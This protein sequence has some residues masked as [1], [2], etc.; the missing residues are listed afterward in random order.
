MRRPVG[1]SRHGGRRRR[2]TR[3]CSIPAATSAI[4][5]LAWTCTCT[6]RSSAPEMS[7]VTGGRS[8]N[9]P[10][11]TDMCRVELAAVGTDG[12]SAPAKLLELHLYDFSE[13]L[14]LELSADGTF[15]IAGRTAASRPRTARPARSPW[16]A[17]WRGCPGPAATS[18]R[19]SCPAGAHD[20]W[21]FGARLVP[22]QVLLLRPGLSISGRRGYR[23]LQMWSPVTDNEPE[24]ERPIHSVVRLSIPLTLRTSWHS[25]AC[26]PVA[27]VPGFV[28]VTLMVTVSFSDILMGVTQW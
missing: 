14:P 16:V 11:T 27:G 28:Q 15:G 12:E 23:A 2:S 20:P 4:M 19:G 3:S 9:S 13:F 8:L 1:P 25:C 5:R 17:R 7:R 21:W 24:E 18:V 6:S 26:R 22:V 10:S